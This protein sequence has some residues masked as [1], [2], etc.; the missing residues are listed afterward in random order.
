MIHFFNENISYTIRHKNNIK[1]WLTEAIIHEGYQ[2]GEISIILCDD[3]YLV[4]LNQQYLNHDTL[5]DIITFDYSE[6]ELI[7]GD[8]YISFERVKENSLQYSENVYNELLRVM[9]HGVL[10]LCG[11]KDKT[12]KDEKLMREKENEN[13]S[14]YFSNNN[15]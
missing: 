10:H 15:L 6:K 2:C 11:Y 3:A 14:K 9:V 1:K 4:P 12:P 13:L 5:T 7:S 8:L